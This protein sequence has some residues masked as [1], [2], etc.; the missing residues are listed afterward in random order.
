LLLVQVA[1]Q[2]SALTGL[3]ELAAAAAARQAE[4]A[5]RLSRLTEV[6]GNLAERGQLLAGEAL[7]GGWGWGSVISSCY[8]TDVE[9]QKQAKLC[10]KPAMLAVNEVCHV[11]F[12][13][14]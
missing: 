1:E 12:V 4:I 2:S 13:H 6:A 10:F 8:C 14:D 7:A 9:R 11:S 3:Q 5:S